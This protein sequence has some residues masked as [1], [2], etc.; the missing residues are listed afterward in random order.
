MNKNK[1]DILVIAA[2]PDDAEL[3]CGGVIAKNT[4]MGKKVGIIDLTKGE[5]G[6]RGTAD[7]RKAEADRASEILGLSMRH[8]MDM[9]DGFFRNSKEN[10]LALIQQIRKYQPDVILAG[11]PDDRHIDHARGAQLAKDATFLAGLSRIET[12]F[13]AWRPKHLYHF[14]QWK[15]LKPDFAVD[16]TGFL[17]QKIEACLAYKTQFYDPDSQEPATA[18]S[19][20]NFTDS[21]AYRA[22]D[23]GRLVWTDAAEGFVS[24][25]MLAVDNF[26]SFI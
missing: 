16:I 12:D 9:G 23:M 10:Q 22:Y 21:I 11:A 6:T 3:G 24:G 8:N 18:I 20:K 2:H 15:N 14:I 17:D 7:T 19:S 26:D 13:A 5:L 25:Q 4:S 1:L